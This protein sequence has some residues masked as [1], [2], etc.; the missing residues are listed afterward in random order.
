MFKV[1]IATVCYRM[2]ACLRSLSRLYKPSYS[3]LPQSTGVASKNLVRYQQTQTVDDEH[4]QPGDFYTEDHIQLRNSL[5]KVWSLVA[6]HLTEEKSN[7][8]D[9]FR[10]IPNLFV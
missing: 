7:Y 1:S 2:M 5:R 6:L 8:F 3:L 9:Y 4:L 10:S